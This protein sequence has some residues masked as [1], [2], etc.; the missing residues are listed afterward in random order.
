MILKTSKYFYNR[1]LNWFLFTNKERLLIKKKI[2]FPSPK[3]RGKNILIQIQDET[4]FTELF[5]DFQKHK[6]DNITGLKMTTLYYTIFDFIFM[7]FY[8]IKKIEQTFLNRKRKLLHNKL[9]VLYLK[10]P[11]FFFNRLKH[12]SKATKIYNS[13]KEKNQLLSLSYNGIL[14]GD[15]IYD[16]YLRIYKKATVDV[17]DINLIFLIVRTFCEYDFLEKICSKYDTYLTGYTTYISS[18]LPVRIFL[19]NNVKV[20]SFAYNKKGKLLVEND[21]HQFKKYWNYKNDFDKLNSKPKKIKEGLALLDSRTNGNIDLRYMKVNPFD[22]TYKSL[23]EKYDGIMFLHDFTDSNHGYRDMV[24]SDFYDW[25]I[26]TFELIIKHKINIGI[27]PHPNQNTSSRKM[28]KGLMKKYKNL[29]WVDEK[30]SNKKLFSSGIKFGLSVYGT[31][32]TELAYKKI[33]P[34]CCGDNPTINYNFTFN[35]KS[36]EEYLNY[37]LNYKDLQFQENRLNEIGEFIYMNHIHKQ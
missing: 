11:P 17:N 15:L 21:F 35:A 33:K 10:N 22:S 26:F 5:L 29:N 7:P 30:T 12:L 16:S 1:I 19:K 23:N 32:V 28:V 4:Y 18:G 27:K 6:N 20:Y 14:I 37:I 13:I 31:V 9:D 36:K 25:V 8:L 24:F 2:T 34:I 3:L